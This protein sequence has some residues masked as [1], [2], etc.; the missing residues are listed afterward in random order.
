MF[1]PNCHYP[2]PADA[3]QCAKCNQS[4]DYSREHLYFSDTFVFVRAADAHPIAIKVDD[5]IQTY[6][7]PAILSRHRHAVNFGDEAPTGKKKDEIAPLPDQPKLSAPSLKLLTV[8]TDRKI[9]KPGAEAG[10][11]IV[12]PDAPEKEA[13]LEIKLG[14]QKVYEAKAPLN[15]DGLALHRYADFKEGEYT[16]TVTLPNGD[17]AE[18]TFSAVEFTLSP[19]IA[20]LEKHEYVQQHLKFTLGLLVLS[21]PYSGPVEFGL[22]CQ[23]CGDRVVA[24]QKANAKDGKANG[25][26][27]LSGHGGPFHVQVTTPDGYTALVSFPGTG[28]Q[29][30]EHI[31]V[32]PLGQTVEAGL[33]PWEDTTPIRGLYLGAGEMNTTPLMLESAIGARGK[34]KVASDLPLAQVVTFNLRTGVSRV[35]ERTDLKRGSEIEFDADAPYTLF[36][37]GAFTKDKPFTGWGIVFKPLAFDAQLT[38]PKTAKPAEEIDIHLDLRGLRDPEGLKAAFCLLLAYDARLEHESPAPKLAKR[39]Y[40]SIR[41]ATASLTVGDAARASDYRTYPEAVFSTG[42][43]P[44]MPQVQLRATPTDAFVAP[45]AMAPKG[46]GLLK[47]AALPLM[48]AGAAVGAVAGAF[49]KGEAATETLTMVVAPTRMEFPELVHLELFYFEGEASRTIKLGDQIGAWRVRAYVIGGVDVQELTADVQAD[50]PLYAELDLPAIASDGDDITA[51]VN[52]NTRS[53][54]DLVITTLFGETRARVNGSG[55]Q[56]FTIKGP[57][58]V[59]VRIENESGAD[60]SVRDVARPGVQKVTA[61]RLVILENGQTVSGEKV[62][63]YPSVGHVLRDTI[64][65]LLRY[66]FG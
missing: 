64:E 24:T 40:E 22:Q 13:S 19:L 9:Y 26:F 17:R 37:A 6:R 50:K 63:A 56:T 55:A 33:L 5:A 8:I 62:V 46:R 49:A 14:G 32:N 10:I 61:S 23:V 2:N 44:Q 29:E 47:K 39:I 42:A 16:V 30:R 36:H 41:G 20:A 4:T 66:P 28:A 21:R 7:A 59:D 57:G 53:P 51:A 45:A 12:A 34:L 43:F 35:I 54:A 18:C 3:T 52:Y 58:K 31:R 48:A 25:D 27:D 15:R 65:A 1:C 38:V 11:F 60:W